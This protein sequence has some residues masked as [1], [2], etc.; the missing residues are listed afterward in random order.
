M[1]VVRPAQTA[2]LLQHTVRAAARVSNY[3]KIVSEGEE[4]LLESMVAQLCFTWLLVVAKSALQTR[5]N[6]IDSG[7]RVLKVDQNKDLQVSET[8]EYLDQ[9]CKDQAETIIYKELISAKKQILGFRKMKA[10]VRS[11]TEKYIT[12]IEY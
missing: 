1:L 5:G 2:I 9:F 7:L 12:N 4:E 10:Q 6:W 3:E 8:I 11:D